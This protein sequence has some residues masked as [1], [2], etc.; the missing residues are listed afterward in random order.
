MADNPKPTSNSEHPSY[1]HSCHVRQG[2]AVAFVSTAVPRPKWDQRFGNGIPRQSTF[3][4]LLFGFHN[5]M[6][7]HPLNPKHRLGMEHFSVWRSSLIWPRWSPIFNTG[8]TWRRLV[9][10]WW[11]W[12][13]IIRR[14]RGQILHHR[15]FHGGR[16][17]QWDAA[18][19]FRRVL[20]IGW[21]DVILLF[22]FQ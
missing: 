18:W 6:S 21:S 15:S 5:W 2:C 22:D 14:K 10:R 3:N 8:P 4:R 1:C 9:G 16:K 20:L 7:R 12:F 17:R 13:Q 11:L 19:H